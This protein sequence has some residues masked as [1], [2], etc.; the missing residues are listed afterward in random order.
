[1]CSIEVRKSRLIHPDVEES[2]GLA[3]VRP[4]G[5][6]LHQGLADGTAV[7]KDFLAK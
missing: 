2:T 6:E 3:R 5:A 4:S 1:M 7:A